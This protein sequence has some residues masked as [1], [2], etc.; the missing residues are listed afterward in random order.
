MCEAMATASSPEPIV[1]RIQ[2]RRLA[3][4]TPVARISEAIPA[5]RNPIAPVTRLRNEACTVVAKSS[6]AYIPGRPEAR[7]ASIR[8]SLRT[9]ANAILAAARSQAT[10]HIAL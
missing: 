2:A 10:A 4:P 6:A 3:G 5:R 7:C 8:F 9:A 1:T